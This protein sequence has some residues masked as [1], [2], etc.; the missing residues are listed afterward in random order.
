MI[1][2]FAAYCSKNKGVCTGHDL[3]TPPFLKTRLP[4]QV[5]SEFASPPLKFRQAFRQSGCF[6]GDWLVGSFLRRWKYDDQV[7]VQL[8]PA[9]AKYAKD[10][11]DLLLS[12]FF[13]FYPITFL[14]P[15]PGFRVENN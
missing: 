1:I 14:V 4:K 3:H 6:L 9:V 10:G 13:D 2:F 8:L 5:V 7:S 15:N 11:D 12:E